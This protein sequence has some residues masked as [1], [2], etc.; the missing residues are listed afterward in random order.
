MS[1]ENKKIKKNLN[2]NKLKP[3]KN[4]EIIYF[5]IA[6]AVFILS[7][8]MFNLYQN[9]SIELKKA[10]ETIA[11]LKK[12]KGG[13]SDTI[14]NSADSKTDNK[15]KT[16]ADYVY[17]IT[18]PLDEND[19]TQGVI[20]APSS[21]DLK[22]YLDLYKPSKYDSKETLESKK[23]ILSDVSFDDSSLSDENKK[24]FNEGK[25]KVIDELDK[26]IK[27]AK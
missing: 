11:A 15:N 12:E 14:T 23:K 21:V 7:F 6:L 19:T 10:N 2:V 26:A 16:K 4:K 8:F 20:L 13:N 1:E 9:K 17:V 18:Q 24:S 5:L 22:E 3:K 27:D 25:T